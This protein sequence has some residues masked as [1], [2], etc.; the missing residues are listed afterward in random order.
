MF[1]RVLIE[2]RATQALA[3]LARMLPATEAGARIGSALRILLLQSLAHQAHG[4]LPAALAPLD[5]ALT[6]AAPE[7][8][9]RLFVD[10]GPAMRDL[11]HQAAA[12]VS[13]QNV[14]V[15]ALLAAF[16]AQMQASAPAIAPAGSPTSEGLNERELEVLRLIA[17]GHSNREI[18]DRL[19]IALSTV[20][21]H[22]N[23]CYGKLGVHRR[24]QA[25]ARAHELGLI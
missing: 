7:G 23:N 3:L 19:V 20:K 10:E 25:L 16:P 5:R 17:L 2:Q 14:Y 15:K 9:V 22:T 24:T 12:R 13:N 18:A 8:Y 6:L 4:D 1:A 21:T 11:L